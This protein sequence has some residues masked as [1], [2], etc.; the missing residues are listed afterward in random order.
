M[1]NKHYKYP[2]LFIDFP[3]VEN[4]DVPLEQNHAHYLKNVLRKDVGQGLRVFN[5]RDG[6]W[7]AE[8]TALSKKNGIAALTQQIQA[9][10]LH[11]RSI[12]L[13]FSPIKKQR[14]DFVIEKAVELGV[15]DIHPVL[16][17][18][19]ENRKINTD[20]IESQIIEAAEQC[21]RL[22]LPVLH[23]LVPLD[24][25][26]RQWSDGPTIYAC[27]ERCEARPLSEYK[28]TYTQ[29]CAFLIGPEGGLE[30]QEITDI[31]KHEK[32]KPVTLG[33]QILR[34]ET[35]ALYCLSQA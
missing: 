26:L 14:M 15:S 30:E 22:T 7:L 5:G 24:Q 6:E 29:D 9:Q 11:K 33:A 25:K 35:A 3:M 2:R 10:E 31:C 32:V 8:V 4:G 1:M 20:R 21:E 13:L 27:I 23:P 28:E 19:T 12:H 17:K 34:A 16:M 18:R